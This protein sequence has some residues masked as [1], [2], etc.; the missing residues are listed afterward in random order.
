MKNDLGLNCHSG[1]GMKR[2]IKTCLRASITEWVG[3]MEK[4]GCNIKGYCFLGT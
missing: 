2:S 4:E 1:M 3:E